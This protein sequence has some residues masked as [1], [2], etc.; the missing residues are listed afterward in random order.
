MNRVNIGALRLYDQS[1]PVKTED[2]TINSG[3]NLQKGDLVGI[4]TA[5]GNY[6]KSLS[7]STDGSQ[8]PVAVLLDDVDASDAH[9][10][11]V[12]VT[13]GSFFQN[14]LRAGTG[15]DLDATAT[16]LALRRLNI[17]YQ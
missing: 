14:Q 5:S 4:I 3:E 7:A 2:V 15:I 8:T 13:S 9:T 10:A 12:V 1:F 11:G 6:K 16:K 17:Y